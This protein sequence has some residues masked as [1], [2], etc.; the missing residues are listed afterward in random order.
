MEYNQDNKRS[1]R[2][3]VL[4]SGTSF[5]RWQATAIRE[6]IAHGHQVV[7]RV[8]DGR[9][10]RRVGRMQRLARKQFRTL[11]FS[12]LENRIFRPPAKALT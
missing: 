5:Q 3:G 4:C 2:F 7:V 8:T 10:E 6:L 11:L 1:L 9:S 12:V